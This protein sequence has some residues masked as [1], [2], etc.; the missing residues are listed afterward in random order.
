MSGIKSMVS[1]WLLHSAVSGSTITTSCI[2]YVEREREV[3]AAVVKAL[4]HN[5]KATKILMEV[6]RL[7]DMSDV[8]GCN[9]SSWATLNAWIKHDPAWIR[10]YLQHTCRCKCSDM[11]GWLDAGSVLKDLRTV[12]MHDCMSWWS[13]TLHDPRPEMISMDIKDVSLPLSLWKVLNQTSPQL[14]FKLGSKPDIIMHN[15]QVW[16]FKNSYS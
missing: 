12:C 7:V 2:K 4:H 1:V 15:S 10:P 13:S 9:Y 14:N 16:I 11:V 6:F 3:V 8:G 5:D